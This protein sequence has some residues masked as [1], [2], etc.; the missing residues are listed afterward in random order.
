[1]KLFEWPIDKGYRISQYFG[2]NP[3]NY[4]QFGLLGHNGIDFACPVGTRVYSCAT[5]VVREVAYDAKGYGNYIKIEHSWGES[6]YAH[7]S[8]FHVKVNESVGI[9][10]IGLSGNTGNS[11]GPHLHFG[12]RIKPYSRLDGWNGH[13]DPYPYLIDKDNTSLMGVHIINGAGRHINELKRLQPSTV[14]VLDPNPDDI[15]NLKLACPNTI[16]IGRIYKPDNEVEALIRANP[17]EAARQM[18]SAIINHPAFGLIDY[19]QGWVNEVCQVGTDDFKKLVQCEFQRM[20][21][22]TNYKCA[23]FAFSVGQP[24]MPEN[25]RMYYWNLADTALKYAEQNGHIVCLHQYGC[26]PN[27]WGPVNRGGPDWL[28][29]RLEHQVFLN[30]KYKKLKF[31]VTEYG[32]DY[33]IVSGPPER[34]GWNA[35]PHYMNNPKL[36]AQDL[37][38]V[39]LYLSRFKGRILGYCV[40]TLGHNPPWGTYDIQGDVLK[41]LADFSQLSN[42]PSNIE[43]IIGEAGDKAQV[44]QVNPNAALTKAA[45]KDNLLTQVS[46]EKSIEINGI[47][48]IYAKYEN[49]FGDSYVYYVENNKWD[50]V[51]RI[52][53]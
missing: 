29:H 43:D 26:D 39:S 51:K 45:I 17:L 37:Y 12:I 10:G 52:K 36:Y 15:R 30:L 40:F 8:A 13:S 42:P 35:R 7:L 33:L 53:R 41:Y 11:T 31:V 48:W 21:L 34:G 14:L 47:K 25:N 4:A 46:P 32:H 19:W 28:L 1:M 5:G 50:Q 23:I 22:A 9:Q 6:I 16:I 44:I 27:I 2:E 38:N 3:A 49:L 20:K 24:D 18:H